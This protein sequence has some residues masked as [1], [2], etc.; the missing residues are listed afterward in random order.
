M[1]KGNRLNLDESDEAGEHEDGYIDLLTLRLPYDGV[2]V[3]AELSCII[4]FAHFIAHWNGLKSTLVHS[5]LPMLLN[6]GLLFILFVRRTSSAGVVLPTSGGSLRSQMTSKWRVKIVLAIWATCNFIALQN[7]SINLWISS[8]L[9]ATPLVV[10][11]SLGLL[12][13]AKLALR[14]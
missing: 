6:I 12:F 4:W 8:S 2:L 9:I 13:L 10:A 5:C 11:T 3:V 7:H 14:L 1:K